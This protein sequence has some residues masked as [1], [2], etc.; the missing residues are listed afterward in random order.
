MIDISYAS[1]DELF[2]VKVSNSSSHLELINDLA[3][4]FNHES[5]QSGKKVLWDLRSIDLSFMDK[6]TMRAVVDFGL[7]NKQK[8]ARKNAFLVNSKLDWGLVRMYVSYRDMKQYQ[9]SQVFFE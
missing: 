6:E 9:E 7:E 4:F 2:I 3:Q 8:L 1:K 5:H